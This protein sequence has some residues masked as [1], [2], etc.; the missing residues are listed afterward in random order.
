[1]NWYGN[2]SRRFTVFAV[3]DDTWGDLAEIG[4]VESLDV[5][6]DLKSDCLQDG[7]MK[8]TGS[9]PNGMVRIYLEADGDGE[10]ERVAIAT[11]N[12][13]S[14]E[15]AI[16]GDTYSASTSMD[17]V[18]FDASDDELPIGFYAPKGADP[19]RFASMLL[20]RHCE[21]PVELSESDVRLPHTIVAEQKDTVT[22]FARTVLDGTGLRIAID[23]YGRLSITKS[24]E[25]RSIDSSMV[26]ADGI[27]DKTTDG[28]RTVTYSRPFDPSITIGSTVSLYIPEHAIVGHFEVQSQRMADDCTVQEVVSHGIA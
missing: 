15:R 4:R 1:M 19:A 28:V 8:V 3:D 23:G 9:M 12:A 10:R 16:T 25:V 11:M 6:N 14:S 5:T 13:T 7:S 20:M 18:M 2:Y 17:S 27:T 24:E 22:T 26:Y 21:C